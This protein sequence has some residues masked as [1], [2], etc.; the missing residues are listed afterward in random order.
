MNDRQTLVVAGRR[1]N[2]DTPYGAIILLNGAS[3]AGKST[4]ARALQ[5]RLDVPFLRFS[6][7]LFLF[8]GEVLPERRDADGPFAKSAMRQRLFDGYYGCLAALARAGNNLAIDVI[9][10]TMAQ[11]R[12][13][14][15]E[16]APF[17][18]FYVGV[19]CQLPELERRERQRGD[20]GIGEARRDLETVHG[21]GAYDVE[22]DTTEPPEINAD[23][24]AT[25]WMAR[26]GPG[27]FHAF[28]A[29]EA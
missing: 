13:L 26:T 21:F 12:R 11:R 18:V 27:R 6:L 29:R 25:A 1:P 3:S 8:G 10:E 22:V 7:D 19:H 15:E 24:I 5:R 4:L 16:L 14:G 20:R 28:A 23:R 9:V 17:D 2:G